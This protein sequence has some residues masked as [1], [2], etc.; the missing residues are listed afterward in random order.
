MPSARMQ[1]PAEGTSDVAVKHSPV[2]LLLSSFA[3]SQVVGWH[4]LH[5]GRQHSW[6]GRRGRQPQATG[7]LAISALSLTRPSPAADLSVTVNGSHLDLV[8]S[9]SHQTHTFAV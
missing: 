5:G 1:N 9:G 2:F 7:D 3:W 6:R 8:H 4:G